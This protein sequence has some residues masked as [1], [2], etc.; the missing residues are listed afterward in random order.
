MSSITQQT[1]GTKK[2]HLNLRVLVLAGVVLLPIGWMTYTFIVLTIG[3]GIEQVGDYKQVD[4]KAMG[5]FPFNDRTDGPDQVPE[6]YRQLDG[7]KV[8][9]IGQ[10]YSDFA[11]SPRVNRFQLVYS[12]QNCCFNGPPKVQERV[13]CQVPGDKTVPIYDGLSRVYGTLHVRAIREKGMVVSVY[14]L[15]VERVE[16]QT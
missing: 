8:L 15:D 3:Q 4:L 16:P 12:I 1:S 2:W 13:F 7:Q 11:A 14:D 10:M 5:N 6:V 9:L